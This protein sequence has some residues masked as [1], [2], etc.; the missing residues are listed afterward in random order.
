[1]R[2]S[3]APIV[4]LCLTLAACQQAAADWFGTGANRFEIPFVAIGDPGVAADTTGAPNPAGGVGY[5]YWMG[6]YE[7]PEEAVRKANAQ[8]AIEGDPLAITLD[9][10]GP[11]KPAT[12]VSWF[13]AARFVNWLNEQ[14]GASPAY[15]FIDNGER[16]EFRFQPWEPGDPGYQVNN[17]FRN[18][19][20]V[21]VLPTEDEW[22]KAAYYDPA[23][24]V[25]W[26]YPTGS[27]MPPTPVASGVLDGTAVWNQGTGPAD[28]DIAGG[29]S[30]Y[31]T[32]AQGGNASEWTENIARLYPFDTDEFR[33]VRGTAYILSNTPIGMASSWR[34]RGLSSISSNAIGFRVVR[35]PEPESI[36][37]SSL[38]IAF[39]AMLRKT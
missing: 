3:V 34:G 30:P 37:L 16:D 6:K 21:Y 22:Y 19:N 36:V 14:V 11:Q 8:S 18:R 5:S 12:S 35:V 7:V 38:L 39:S 32:V 17:A 13:E 4:L 33:G 10:R 31:G 23:A 2:K 28:I 25:W 29:A 20:A 26:D 27:D 24:S 1:M 9:E 15:K